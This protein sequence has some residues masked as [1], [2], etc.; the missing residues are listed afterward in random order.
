MKASTV[1]VL[2]RIN[3][4]FYRELAS[5][6]SETRKRPWPGWKRLFDLAKQS[7]GRMVGERSASERDQARLSILDLGCGNGRLLPELDGAFGGGVSYL[8]LDASVPLLAL[9]ARTSGTTGASPVSFVA[10]DL[11][12]EPLAELESGPRFD[13]ILAFGFLHHVPSLERRHRVLTAAVG[14]LGPGGLLAVSFWQFGDRERF[15]RR[16]LLWEALSPRFGRLDPSDLEPGDHLL[17]W[18][19]SGAVRYCHH[20]APAEAE[21]LVTSLGLTVVACFAADGESGDMNLYYL[22]RRT[23]GSEPAA[24]TE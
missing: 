9:A 13:L 16:F 24:R 12:G 1:E 6:F 20:A 14:L 17:A 18:G 11:V 2:D 15:R 3:R 22:L 7:L 21:R 19:E 8:G 5:E 23:P 4:D 10:S